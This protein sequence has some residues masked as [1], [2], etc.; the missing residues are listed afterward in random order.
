M[1][2]RTFIRGFTIVEM[3][4][5]I[6][7]LGILAGMTV[8]GYGAWQDS[9]RRTVAK[10]DLLHARSALEDARNFGTT[11]YPVAV[12]STFKPSENVQLTG[13]SFNSGANYCIQA[14]ST[15]NASIVYKL[16]DTITDPEE[17]TC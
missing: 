1:S 4:V 7:V 9:T 12:P 13:G 11:G 8:I 14:V 15:I 3:A 2:R 6:A 5:V 17:G 10:S 16:T